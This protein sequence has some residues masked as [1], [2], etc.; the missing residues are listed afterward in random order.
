MTGTVTDPSTLPLR[1][2]HLPDAPGWWPPP[3]GWWLVAAAAVV[4]LVSIALWR[5][6]VRRRREAAALLFD[7]TVDAERDSAARV[8]AIS[9]L[10]R[11]AARRRD[12]SADR[13]QGANWLH[14]LDEG[15]RVRGARTFAEVGGVLLDGGFR[16]EVDAAAI[17]ALR[18]VARARFVAL[19]CHARPRRRWPWRRG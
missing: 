10:L 17:E 13:L 5:R 9:E 11:R 6:R 19:M 16:R 3:P 4:L 1:D 15:P 12:P 7:T 14:F 2:A 8:A 18:P